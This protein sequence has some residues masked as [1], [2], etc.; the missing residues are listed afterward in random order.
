M[1]CAN[2]GLLGISPLTTKSTSSYGA[3]RAQTIV[4]GGPP[5]VD[6]AYMQYL[7]WLHR[8][9]RLILR[10]AYDDRHIADLPNSYDEDAIIWDEY[11]TIT[12]DGRQPE[13]AP[14]QNYMVPPLNNFFS[15]PFELILT[16]RFHFQGQQLGRLANEAGNVLMV[17]PGSEHQ[18]SV[19][20]NFVHHVTLTLL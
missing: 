19:L 7:F 6:E 10:P 17:P 1:T 5:H 12:R 18:A 16:N 15:S 4:E 9:A 20:R 8:N 11:D 3:N 2:A 14:L 13:R